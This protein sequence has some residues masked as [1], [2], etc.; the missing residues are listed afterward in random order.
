MLNVTALLAWE[1]WWMS[2]GGNSKQGHVQSVVANLTQYKEFSKMWSQ[3]SVNNE[4]LGSPL[5]AQMPISWGYN[6]SGILMETGWQ[7][8][9]RNLKCLPLSWVSKSANF[10][11]P[12]HELMFQSCNQCHLPHHCALVSKVSWPDRK[13]AVWLSVVARVDKARIS[14]NKPFI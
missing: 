7:R 2:F 13:V 4:K 1:V 14:L 8:S 12:M 5:G 11:P 6:G 10:P 3:T 9:T